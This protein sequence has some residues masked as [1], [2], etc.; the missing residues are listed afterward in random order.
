MT[1]LA[2][3]G[4]VLHTPVPGSVVQ[5]PDLVEQDFYRF[6][7]QLAPTCDDSATCKQRDEL[8]PS[9]ISPRD[10]F[11][12][13]SEEATSFQAPDSSVLDSSGDRHNQKGGPFPPWNSTPSV[14]DFYRE[15]LTCN[16]AEGLESLSPVA[17]QPAATKRY[18]HANGSEDKAVAVN[19]CTL[20]HDPPGRAPFDSSVDRKRAANRLAQKT[21][22][23]K[24]KVEFRAA[25]APFHVRC[26]VT[27][28]V[29]FH[30]P[31]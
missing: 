26:A 20:Q 31:Y 29:M 16:L 6:V 13:R 15:E 28:I 18:R 1:T 17:W 23:N 14:P 24:Q 3:P 8:S 2:D 12:A 10:H 25:R 9:D 30:S 7:A 4:C 5:T 22:R 27:M 11:Q 19:N 21:F